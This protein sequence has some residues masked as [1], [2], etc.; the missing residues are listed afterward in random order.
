MF[1]FSLSSFKV[2]SRHT[3]FEITIQIYCVCHMEKA[4]D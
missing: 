4:E 2:A 3:F 1:L